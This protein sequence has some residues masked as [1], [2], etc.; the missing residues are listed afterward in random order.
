MEAR[1][2][3][4]ARHEIA[5]FLHRPSREFAPDVAH[6]PA[7][8]SRTIEQVELFHLTAGMLDLARTAAPTVPSFALQPDDLPAPH[9]LL[10]TDDGVFQH[11]G[12]DPHDRRLPLVALSWHEI[13]NR[14]IYLVGYNSR[15]DGQGVRTAHGGPPILGLPRFVPTLASDLLP[16][17]TDRQHALS[18]AATTDWHWTVSLLS[19][20]W[21]LMQQRTIATQSQLQQDR[22]GRRHAQRHGYTPTPVRLI[23]LRGGHGS[24]TGTSDRE[25]RHQWIVRGHWRQ[26][27]YPTR[28]VHRPV[29]IVPHAKGPA[30]APLLGGDKVNV[31]R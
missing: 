19:A 29:W 14:G 2:L 5:E 25:Y 21:L 28:E 13:P 16:Y 31:V 22:P 1:E 4:A 18:E 15:E 10:T 30:D 11:Y 7:H 9:G 12:D 27:W 24:N 6:W 17:D 20:A 26:Q 8:I 3:P 23:D